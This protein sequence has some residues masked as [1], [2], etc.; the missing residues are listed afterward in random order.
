MPTPARPTLRT[1]R[2]L[3][4]LSGWD[5]V[6]H[7]R[8]ILTDDIT[9]PVWKL[10]HPAVKKAAD[11]FPGDH[12]ATDGSHKYISGLS[13]PRWLAIKTQ[14]FRGAVWE[15]PATGQAWLCDVGLR[16]AGQEEDFY[17]SFM[18]AV[19]AG[20][21]QIYYPTTE[22]QQ[23]LLQETTGD[24]MH[25]WHRQVCE[26]AASACVKALTD[27]MVSYE[28]IGP[29]DDVLCEV[30]I[31]VEE[32]DNDTTA[33]DDTT[34]SDAVEVLVELEWKDWAR[35]AAEGW[36]AQLIQTSINPAELEWRSYP[37]NGKPNYSIVT[38]AALVRAGRERTFG[39]ADEELGISIPG[40]LAHHCHTTDIS[41]S[42]VTGTA[43]KALCGCWF[44]HRAS[45]DDRP[46]CTKCEAIY[47]SLPTA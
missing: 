36:V 16:R 22:D 8:M 7:Q 29:G 45:G 25:A 34:A 18:A 12:V 5:S 1:L 9:V 32:V 2:R 46:R 17:A 33:P 13:N 35:L 37:I 31:V 41:K 44:V 38:T 24:A 26:Q 20:G 11:E 23:L 19:E 42:V 39:L 28:L 10:E 15:D 40:T 4:G 21:P 27:R 43:M 14:Q 47:E 30:T 3:A 6:D